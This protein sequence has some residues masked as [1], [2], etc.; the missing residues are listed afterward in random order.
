MVSVMHGR[1][2]TNHLPAEEE[3]TEQWNSVEEE[4][5]VRRDPGESKDDKPDQN[6]TE[7]DINTCRQSEDAYGA[8]ENEGDPR[9]D[10]RKHVYRL[11]VQIRLIDDSWPEDHG[12]QASPHD[13]NDEGDPVLAQLIGHKNRERQRGERDWEVQEDERSAEPSRETGPAHVVEL[14]RRQSGVRDDDFDGDDE[15]QRP[16]HADWKG[17]HTLSHESDHRT[18]SCP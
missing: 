6:H 12:A 11:S 9:A 17:Q 7:D 14:R 13:R 16:H 18:P 10:R 5:E 4:P 2:T 15:K 3:R 8:G 1:V